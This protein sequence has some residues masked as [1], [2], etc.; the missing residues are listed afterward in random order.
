MS[1]NKEL[2]IYIDGASKGNPG[3]SGA[4]IV[5]YDHLS[6]TAVPVKRIGE[7]LGETTNNAAEYLAFI[8][9]LQ[10]AV[11]LEG[12]HIFVY[13]DS[14]LLARQFNGI[15]KIKN[16]R[17]KVIYEQLQDLVKN[18]EQVKIEYIPRENNKLA[19]KLASDAVT[20]RNKIAEENKE[21]NQPTFKA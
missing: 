9:A 16:E 4:G 11:D 20:Q 17:L 13:T 21:C 19:D 10:E 7:Y 3:P 8:F 14:E 12:T 2:F 18:F 5:I 6:E 1:K 15:Y